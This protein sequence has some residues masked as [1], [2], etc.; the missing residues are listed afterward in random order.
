MYK[1]KKDKDE[2]VKGCKRVYEDEQNGYELVNKYFVDNSGLG[3]S[4]EL[5]LTFPRFLDKVS[6]HLRPNNIT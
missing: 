6:S 2:E 1:A 5:A 4:D 3:A